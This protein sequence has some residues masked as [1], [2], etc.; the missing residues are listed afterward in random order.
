M[1]QSGSVSKLTSFRQIVAAP[2]F[3]EHGIGVAYGGSGGIMSP[4]PVE[5]TLMS[6]RPMEKTLAAPER[7]GIACRT[8]F[9]R[10]GGEGV[11][12][13]AV[14]AGRLAVDLSGMRSGA[15]AGLRA[16]ML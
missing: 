5:N 16:L 11:G 12:L 13:V 4:M 6:T 14:G 10:G 8:A 2:G 7:L 15:S 9:R 3:R 1:R